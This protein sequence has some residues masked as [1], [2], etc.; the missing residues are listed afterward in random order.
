MS[1]TDEQ[2]DRAFAELQEFGPRRG[3]PV[4]Q[5]WRESLRDVGAEEFT[6]LKAR[7]DE[8]ESFALGLAEQVR[9]EQMADEAARWQL[10]QTY[11]FLTRERLAR[12][13]SQAM[14]FS[15]K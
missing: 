6:S 2:F 3:I 8:I 15:M 5:R 9:D 14:Y 1:V 12:T 7:C 11:P 4:E 13:W 10:A